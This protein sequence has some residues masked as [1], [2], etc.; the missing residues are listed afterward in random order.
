MHISFTGPECSGKSTAATWLGQR[1]SGFVLSEYAIQYLGK[2]DRAY[3][4]GDVEAIA[5]EQWI[6]EQQALRNHQHVVCDTDLLVCKIWYEYR[7]RMPS[8]LINRMM[9]DYHP[10]HIF[11]CYPDF[12][13]KENPFRESPLAA[14]RLKLFELYRCYLETTK[15]R[16]IVLSGSETE[17]K[18]M[19]QAFMDAQLIG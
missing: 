8:P 6:L 15:L 17:R 16:F 13:W 10:N 14:E 12:E 1:I 11:L 2:L 4:P 9:E 3:L 19:M 7:F 18:Q 5:Q